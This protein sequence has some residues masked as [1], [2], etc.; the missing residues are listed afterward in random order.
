MC[1]IVPPK[2]WN[3]LG[4][5]EKN[6]A[7][8]KFYKKHTN[9]QDILIPTPIRQYVEGVQGMY[10]LAL[11]EEKEISVSEFQQMSEHEEFEILTETERKRK[12]DQDFKDLEDKFWKN[13]R[14]SPPLYG[15]DMSGNLFNQDN[16][17]NLKKLNN[18][19][20]TIT[21]NLPGIN[22]PYLY[23]GMWKAMFAW[24]I[25]DMNFSSI[26]YIHFGQ[27]KKWY[28]IPPQYSEEFENFSR[29]EFKE[30]SECSEFLRHKCTMIHPNQILKRNIPVYST[31][32]KAGEFMITY[33]Y[34]YHAG[35]NFGFNCAESVNF[36]HENWFKYGRNANICK[37][38]DFSARIDVQE[39]E[40]TYN[41]VKNENGKHCDDIDC[42]KEFCIYP[43]KRKNEKELPSRKKLCG[44]ISN[45]L[46]LKIKV[47]KSENDQID[48]EIIK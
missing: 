12:T 40:Y 31:V 23:F 8:Y 32:H 1:K 28:C 48:Y 19:L 39:L 42:S 15:A 30:S 35:F 16:E 13:L 25:E 45:D 27:P 5:K 21:L 4:R 9:V 17:W 26:N 47:L 24:H 22:Q 29:K 6:Y 44:E 11:M 38:V 2:E 33:P 36:C 41:L 20:N 14:Y 46:I 34:A 43:K 37:C 3:A 18:L 10:Q 7:N